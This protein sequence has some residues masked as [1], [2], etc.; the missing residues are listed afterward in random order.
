M[1]GIA[2]IGAVG[3]NIL[4]GFTGQ[5]SLGHAAFLGIGAYTTAILATK[6]NAPIWLALPLSGLSA[7][8]AGLSVGVPCLRLK[9]LYLAMATMVF[10]FIVE[11]IIVHWNA[12][13]NGVAGINLSRPQV[14]NFTFE[15]DI[16]FYYL[17]I[18]LTLLSIIAA[19]NII[20]TKTGRA[21]MAIRDSDTA[22]EVMGINIHKYKLIAFLVS[23]FYAGIAG[24]LYA[25]YLNYISGDSFSL[26][27]SIEYI[28][29]LIVGGMGSIVGSVFGAV[30]M[31]FLPETIR[32]IIDIFRESYP[33]L[34]TLFLDIRGG[35]YGIFIMLFLI[36]QPDGMYGLWNDVKVFFLTWPYKR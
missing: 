33:Q 35:I 5:V 9:S 28:A 7:S 29:M 6:F 12:V 31:T 30:F 27:V 34:S 32:S 25:Y 24:S 17:I 16:N 18:F 20:R 21:L 22:A 15:S 8:L 14:G 11:Y 10:G 2:T 36:F 3:L 19:K 23:S 4:T 26:L 1:A 13:T